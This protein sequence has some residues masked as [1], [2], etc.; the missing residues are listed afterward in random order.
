MQPTDEQHIDRI[1]KIFAVYNRDT[2]PPRSQRERDLIDAI[3]RARY[4]WCERRNWEC[5][6]GS[7]DRCMECGAPVV[8]PSD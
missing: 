3:S 6:P 5:L 7:D 4:K 8:P 1:L 2:H